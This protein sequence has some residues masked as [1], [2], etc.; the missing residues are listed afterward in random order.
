MDDSACEF[1]T[2]DKSDVKNIKGK[3]SKKEHV[4]SE[5]TECKDESGKCNSQ[6]DSVSSQDCKKPTQVQKTVVEVSYEDFLKSQKAPQKSE[7]TA[8]EEKQNCEPVS[9]LSVKPKGCVNISNFFSKVSKASIKPPEVNKV[10]TVQAVIHSPTT[11]S[12]KTTLPAPVV[13]EQTSAKGKRKKKTQGKSNVVVNHVDMSI[14]CLDSENTAA[15][16]NNT[17][18]ETN[19]SADCK[20][21]PRQNVIGHNSAESEGHECKTANNETLAQGPESSLTED[22]DCE[23]V[24][25]EKSAQSPELSQTEDEDNKTVN[26]EKS[27]HGPEAN[28]VEIKDTNADIVTVDSSPEIDQSAPFKLAESSDNKPKPTKEFSIFSK[29]QKSVKES[30]SVDTA[31]STKQIVDTLSKEEE[32]VTIT[33]EISANKLNISALDSVKTDPTK[34]TSRATLSFGK[35]GVEVKKKTKSQDKKIVQKSQ[36][37]TEVKSDEAHGKEKNKSKKKEKNKGETPVL[38]K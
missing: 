30:K 8:C 20:S 11:E 34:K 1:E 12:V 7:D 2:E 18:R 25:H 37:T 16:N 13:Y 17:K 24:S 22:E 33:S 27:A 28:V 31:K 14:I 9:D 5:R 19:S 21:E 38:N 3:N 32:D 4:E 29:P 6:E 23:T 15:N 35:S 36:D 26:D 10:L